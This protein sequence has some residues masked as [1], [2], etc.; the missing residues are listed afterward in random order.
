M[1]PLIQSA[2]KPCAEYHEW[3]SRYPDVARALLSDLEPVPDFLTFEHVGSTA[4][5][6]CGGKRVIDLLALYHYDSLEDS[7]EFLLK[8]GF[9]RQ[10]PE[11]ARAWPDDRPMYLG[12]YNCDLEVFLIYVHVIHN[13]SDEVRRF[14]AFVTHLSESPELVAEYCECKRN[15]VSSGVTDTDEYAIQKRPFI[16]KALGTHNTLKRSP[17]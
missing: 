11:F 6:G 7:K 3:D 12:S 9:V 1:H 13:A 5:P 14:R 15:I 2:S 17:D 10:G 16:H 8:H 4:I